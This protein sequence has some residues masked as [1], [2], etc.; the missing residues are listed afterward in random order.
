[1]TKLEKLFRIAEDNC[2]VIEY[3]KFRNNILGIYYKEPDVIPAIGINQ[4]IMNDSNKLTCVLAEELGHH[5]TTSDDLTAEYYCYSDAVL[6][7]K[8]ELLALKWAAHMLLTPNEIVQAYAA[9]NNTFECA[10]ILEVTEDF[11]IKSIDIFKR[12]NLFTADMDR[13]LFF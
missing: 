2:I 3:V 5:F 4:L 10:D 12:E 6:T 11:L 1:M 9:C 13:H 7:D 8:A